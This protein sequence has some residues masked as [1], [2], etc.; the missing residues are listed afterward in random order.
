VADRR[1]L[2]ADEARR[3]IE[4]AGK[5]GR[6]PFRGKVLVR[7]VFRHGLRASAA[8]GMRWSQVDLDQGAIHVARI[9]VSKDST[10]HASTYGEPRGQRR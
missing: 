5:R 3:L 6:Y 1:Y 8:V 4:A 10:Q 2:R 7:L 9:K